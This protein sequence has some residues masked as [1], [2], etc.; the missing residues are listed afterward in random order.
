[1]YRAVAILLLVP[2]SLMAQKKPDL[3]A[4]LEKQTYTSGKATLNY[5]FLKP[6]KLEEK[7][8]YPLVIFLHGAGERGD[9]NTVQMVHGVGDFAKTATRKKHP[10]FLI[11]PQCP[12]NR[13]WV[14][15][16][17]SSDSHKMPKDPSEPATLVLELVEKLC[18]EHPI[19]RSRIYLT[20][21][22]MGGYGTW[23][24]LA[25]QPKLFAAGIPICGGGDEKQAKTMV[26]IPIWA[27]HGDKDTAV[28]VERSRKMI[29]AIKKAGG[30][31]KYTEYPGVG[32]DSWTRT[33]RNAEVIDWLFAQ[34][35]K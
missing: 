23:D 26:A 24:L 15:V 14:E 7:K 33:Y 21:L 3:E 31:P 28:K 25:R 12:K 34:Q 17:W 19:D 20:G 10:C 4:L 13:R 29:E 5:R 30:E 22:S 18:K 32:H 35:K 8:T 1:M 27:F 11:A 6:E 16:D 9:D 2:V